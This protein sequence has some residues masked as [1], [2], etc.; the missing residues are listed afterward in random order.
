M[1]QESQFSFLNTTWFLL[2]FH[3]NFA[4]FAEL[5]SVRNNLTTEQMQTKF[6]EL[7]E[8]A[9]SLNKKLAIIRGDGE[10][11]ISSSDIARVES[12]LSKY[13][14]EWSRRKRIFM[15]IWDTVSENLD[16]KQADLFEDI[17]IDSDESIGELLSKYQ[18]LVQSMSSQNDAKRV[19]LSK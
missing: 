1:V 14:K 3:Q 10:S 5:S 7:Q 13:V 11:R 12:K 2:S 17:G 18:K 8:V 9:E 19:R 16:G 4:S 6:E 15:N